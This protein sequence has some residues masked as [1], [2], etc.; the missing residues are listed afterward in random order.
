M[1]LFSP[2]FPDRVS[3]PL[4][5]SFGMSGSVVLLIVSFLLLALFRQA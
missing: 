2:S 4:S 5:G 3:F 1:I